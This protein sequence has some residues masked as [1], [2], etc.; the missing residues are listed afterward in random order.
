VI[1]DGC[2]YRRDQVPACTFARCLELQPDYALRRAEA[3]GPI[4]FLDPADVPVEDGE[5]TAWYRSH[6]RR[7]FGLD[8]DG[9][10]APFGLHDLEHKATPG[11]R[12]ST[13]WPATVATST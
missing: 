12:P 1:T 10:V 9:P 3:G 7:F 8:E 13:P 5:F 11:G 4:P 6:A 2:S